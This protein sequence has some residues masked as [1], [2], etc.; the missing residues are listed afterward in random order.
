MKTGDRVR[1]KSTGKEGELLELL[2][3]DESMAR[4]HLDTERWPVVTAIENLE[5]VRGEEN[6]EPPHQDSQPTTPYVQWQKEKTRASKLEEIAQFLF[7]LLDTIDALDD[8]ARNNDGGF[9]DQVRKVQ[10]RRFE[11]ASTDGYHVWWTP[12][13]S[14]VP[15][16][17]IPDEF[18]APR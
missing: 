17:S 5:L 1:L 14:P 9:R 12:G 4:I 15:E 7:S 13:E 18:R 16:A 11:V 8:A 3:P 6:A 2:P 10:Q